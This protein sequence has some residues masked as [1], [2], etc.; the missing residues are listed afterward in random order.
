MKLYDLKLFRQQN[1]INGAWQDDDCG[2]I[3]HVTNP[4]TS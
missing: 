3:I 2:V 1:Y 4:A